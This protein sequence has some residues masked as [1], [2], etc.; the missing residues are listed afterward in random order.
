MGWCATWE[1]FKPIFDRPSYDQV[2]ADWF[3]DLKLAVGFLREKHAE[4]KALG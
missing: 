1:S 2:E 4:I 3:P